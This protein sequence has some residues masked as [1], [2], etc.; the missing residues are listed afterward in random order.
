MDDVSVR[1]LYNGDVSSSQLGFALNGAVVGLAEEAAAAG[2]RV[3]RDASQLH[4]P[5][6]LCLG[7][8]LVRAVDMPKRLLFV[9]SP[10]SLGEM[11]RVNT[12]VV[13]L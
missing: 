3:G 8:G 10:L 1:F 11:Q 13:S 4:R 12:L 9:L 5:P 6:P 7:I 2:E